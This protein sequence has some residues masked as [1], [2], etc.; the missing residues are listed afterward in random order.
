MPRICCF[1]TFSLLPCCTFKAQWYLIVSVNN[2]LLY[3]SGFFPFLL[4]L[5]QHL[6]LLLQIFTQSLASGSLVPS[7]VSYSYH[8][9]Q[10]GLA[11]HLSAAPSQMLCLRPPAPPPPP[12]HLL[13][14]FSL[15]YQFSSATSIWP[16]CLP[17]SLCFN[18]S[19]SSKC[20]RCLAWTV[21]ASAI[22]LL[23]KSLCRAIP[24]NSCFLCFVQISRAC[25]AGRKFS[26]KLGRGLSWE[27]LLQLSES[28]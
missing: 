7:S 16:T 26:G 25:C 21:L 5:L 12:P 28:L 4:F 2:Q 15:I 1:Q 6:L 13:C 18:T 10:P 23:N 3:R 14:S 22:L 9:P 20:S 24:Y 17:T 19:V 11:L 27:L 8:F